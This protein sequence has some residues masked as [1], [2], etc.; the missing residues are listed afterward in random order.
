VAIY[1]L[2]FSTQEI[3]LTRG[4]CSHFNLGFI[5]CRVYFCVMRHMRG[6]APGKRLIENE[7]T[8]FEQSPNAL[9]KYQFKSYD[10]CFSASSQAELPLLALPSFL[11]LVFVRRPLHRPHHAE[12]TSF[13]SLGIISL[14][15]SLMTRLE[16]SFAREA[17]DN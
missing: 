12:T 1:G 3:G 5:G 7:A 4:V 16:V 10:F 8:E 11:R 9:C 6:S 17:I 15:A 13:A 2:D 14:T